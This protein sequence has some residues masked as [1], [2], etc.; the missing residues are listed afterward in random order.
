MFVLHVQSGK[1]MTLLKSGFQKR[2]V[3]KLKIKMIMIIVCVISEVN[4]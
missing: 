4:Y 3:I 2:A 1:S